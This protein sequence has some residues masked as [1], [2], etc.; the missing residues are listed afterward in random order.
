ML[1]H[2]FVSSGVHVLVQ[3]YPNGPLHKLTPTVSKEQSLEIY[4]PI[5]LLPELL[6]ILW[7]PA[8][9]FHYQHLMQVT[10]SLSVSPTFSLPPSLSYNAPP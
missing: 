1:L 10:S 5:R 9:E 6:V 4:E 3:R 7:D 2:V 8:T